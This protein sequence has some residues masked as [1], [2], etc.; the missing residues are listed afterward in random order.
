MFEP[1][2]QA[3]ST[4][5]RRHGGL[6]IGLSIARRLVEMHDGTIRGESAGSGKGSTFTVELP[7]SPAP[8]RECLAPHLPSELKPDPQLRIAAETEHDDA[9]DP[10]AT[11]TGPLSGVRV[12]VV[13]DHPDTCRAIARLLR[14]LGGDVAIAPSTPA[15]LADAR[16]LWPRVLLSDIGMPGQDGY[17]LIRTLRM[18][19]N[20]AIPGER[21][22]LYAIALTAFAMPEDRAKALTAGFDEYLP[23]PVNFGDLLEAVKHGSAGAVVA[24]C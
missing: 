24:S 7:L 15:A 17:D 23:K 20:Q 4:T 6:G 8:T 13:D 1:F 9:S 11:V 22:R 2:R 3:D 5:T 10:L 18:E 21:P 16:T 14:S 12:L 19:E